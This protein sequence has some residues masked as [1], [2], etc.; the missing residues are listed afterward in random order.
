MPAK[1]EQRVKVL[2]LSAFRDCGLEERREILDGRSGKFQQC[3]IVRRG[4]LE[5]NMGLTGPALIVE[6]Q[7]TTYV[8][9]GFSAVVNSLGYIILSSGEQGEEP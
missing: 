5:N 7:T 4:N 1:P 6:E 3:A 9:K 2:H 8:P